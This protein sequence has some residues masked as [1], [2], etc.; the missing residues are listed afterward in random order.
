MSL[1]STAELCGVSPFD[2]LA[3]LHRHSAELHENAHAWMPWN[4]R[5]TFAGL[6]C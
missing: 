3:E 2:Y 6:A 1:I 4:Y 5:E